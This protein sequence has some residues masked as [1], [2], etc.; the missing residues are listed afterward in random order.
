MASVVRNSV[1]SLCVSNM[2][3]RGLSPGWN[4]TARKGRLS[5]G[6]TSRAPARLMADCRHSSEQGW[7]VSHAALEFHFTPPLRQDTLEREGLD[8]GSGRDWVCPEPSR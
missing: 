1:A 2:T 6:L 7:R 5:Y 4:N 8:M 3:T